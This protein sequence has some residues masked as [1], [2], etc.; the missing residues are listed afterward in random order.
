MLP[1]RRSS[2]RGRSMPASCASPSLSPED[3][4]L[5]RKLVEASE[6]MDVQDGLGRLPRSVDGITFDS[7]TE[8]RRH[9][10]LRN[11]EAAGLVLDLTLQPSFEL[12]EAFTD[13]SGKRHR[14]ITYAVDFA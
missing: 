7:Q 1:D 5:T 10:V 6:L 11:R 3:V 13:G 12:Q 9:T 14:A 2:A 4:A 8:A